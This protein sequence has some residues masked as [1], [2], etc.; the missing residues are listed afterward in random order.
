MCYYSF[1]VLNL[2][3]AVCHCEEFIRGEKTRLFFLTYKYSN[4][5]AFGKIYPLI[6]LM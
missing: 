1:H 2:C 6:V 4:Y 5:N 3:L